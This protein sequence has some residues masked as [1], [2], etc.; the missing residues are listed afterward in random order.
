MFTGT[1]G[2]GAIDPGFFVGV[3]F[4]IGGRFERV[5]FYF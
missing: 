4:D 5:C 1:A 3:G 2:F